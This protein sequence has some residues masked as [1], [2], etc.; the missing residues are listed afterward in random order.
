MEVSAVIQLA[1]E[2]RDCK[3]SCSILKTDPK[4]AYIN[5]ATFHSPLAR[6]Q[7]SGLKL[8]VEV[9]NL[10]SKKLG[11]KVFLCVQ[12]GKSRF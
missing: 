7:L 6:T 5:L 2:Q 11:D 1:N 3:I 8:T 9:L 4:I 12:E 10:L